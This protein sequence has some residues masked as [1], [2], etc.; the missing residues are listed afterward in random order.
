MEEKLLDK[1]EIQIIL[2]NM[3][4]DFV[5]YC[6]KYQLRYYLVG[7]TLLG[8]VRHHG[9]IPWDDDIDVGMPRADYNR[10][11]ELVKSDPIS[12][13]YEVFSSDYDTL[14]IP[15]T[16]IVNKNVR[17]EKDSSIYIADRYQMLNLF[18]DIIPQDG[19]PSDATEAEKLVK[20]MN[21]LRFMN[22]V[23]R[24]KIGHGKNLI[25]TMA[26]IPYGIFVKLI[27]NKKILE[28]IKKESIRYDYD[29][30]E[31]VG[32]VA[33]GIYGE[34][35]RCLRKEVTDFKKLDFENRKYN[36]PGCW[37]SYL[38]GIYGND[39]MELPPESKRTTHNM[40]AFCDSDYYESI[41]MNQ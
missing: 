41:F 20:K 8:A 6:E 33:Y 38:S 4:D 24:A 36:A 26:K 27:G 31:Y 11:L 34:G 15:L 19:W 22:Q 25:R 5:N 10:F 37:E 17:L 2:L 18:I 13:E 14:T 3:L 40:T 39:F 28:R 32:C 30:S 1:N 21:H 23:S 9:F 29:K 35:E 12:S 16:E 7:G